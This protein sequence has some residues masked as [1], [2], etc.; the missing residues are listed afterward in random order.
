MRKLSNGGWVHRKASTYTE[1]RGRTS[2]SPAR[3][4]PMNGLR[5]RE[6]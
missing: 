3:F 4:E 1:K 5:Q 2:M 6:P